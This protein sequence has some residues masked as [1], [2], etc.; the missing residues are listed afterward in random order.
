MDILDVVDS[1]EGIFG[2]NR[3]KSHLMYRNQFPNRAVD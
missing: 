2:R 3:Q 1:S